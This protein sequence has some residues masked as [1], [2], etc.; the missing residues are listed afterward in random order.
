MLEPQIVLAFFITH[1]LGRLTQIKIVRAAGISCNPT[2]SPPSPP[3]HPTQ[4]F[5]G[6]IPLVLSPAEGMEVCLVSCIPKLFAGD[7]S[8]VGASSKTASSTDYELV[9]FSTQCFEV[10]VRRR[11]TVE[12]RDGMLLILL[13]APTPPRCNCR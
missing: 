5:Q 2:R 12:A 13:L 8:W 9:Q 10:D 11:S 4:F 7:E 3:P 6:E 1:S